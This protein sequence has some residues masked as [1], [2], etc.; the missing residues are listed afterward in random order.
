MAAGFIRGE[1]DIREIDLMEV[2]PPHL[3]GFSTQAQQETFA[4]GYETQTGI[5]VRYPWESEAQREARRAGF[6]PSAPPE[7]GG[8]PVRLRRSLERVVNEIQNLTRDNPQY[9]TIMRQLVERANK[10]ERALGLQETVVAGGAANV[11]VKVQ[12]VEPS[13]EALEKYEKFVALPS[14]KARL[15]S[16][17]ATKDREYLQLIKDRH[18]DPEV[19]QV[20]TLR[21]L[22]LERTT[23]A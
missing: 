11:P 21:L 23:T 15:D 7:L 19:V 3:R 2:L 8:D 9:D 13:K 20:A 22:E 18:D 10:Y 6:T 4:R 1:G 12:D 5:M 17:K 14:K 16:A